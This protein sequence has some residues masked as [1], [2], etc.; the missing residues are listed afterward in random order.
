MRLA[1]KKV[2]FKT[3][4]NV[5]EQ[6]VVVTLTSLS[7]KE[8]KEL[9]SK[10]TKVTFS[11]KGDRHEEMD[12]IGFGE[13]RFDAVLVGWEGVYGSDGQPLVCDSDTKRAVFQYN[14][15]FVSAV[16]DAANDFANRAEALKEEKRGN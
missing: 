3:K 14:S 5:G 13:D 12:Y 8:D 10:N 9:A 11:K 6:E 16:L 4:I 1:T 2:E 15:E 7:K